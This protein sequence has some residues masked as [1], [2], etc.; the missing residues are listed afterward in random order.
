MTPTKRNS[1]LPIVSAL[2]TLSLLISAQFAAADFRESVSND[3]RSQ[4]ETTLT[5]D[6]KTVSNET[7]NEVVPPKEH[8]ETVI[9]LSNDVSNP[10]RSNMILEGF[11]RAN[12]NTD[13]Q[14]EYI[15][16]RGRDSAT[17]SGAADSSTL[18]SNS[19]GW[20]ERLAE[21]K[22]VDAV[23]VSWLEELDYALEKFPDAWIVN[24]TPR[25]VQEK[26]NVINLGGVFSEYADETVKLIPK[27]PNRSQRAWVITGDFAKNDKVL[28]TLTSALTTAGM[29]D[30]KLITS[31]SLTTLATTLREI[32]REDSIIYLPISY[33]EDGTPMEAIEVIKELGAAS[34]APILSMWSAFIG[35]GAIGGYVFDPTLAGQR[36]W[37]V[38]KDINQ[39]G[40]PKPSYTNAQWVID[41]Q[42]LVRFGGAKSAFNEQ[43]VW[44][45]PVRPFSLQ[46]M[47]RVAW[48]FIATATLVVGLL[49]FFL[50]RE[51]KHLG[52]VATANETLRAAEKKTEHALQEMQKAY[53]DLKNLSEKRD[54]IFGIVAHELRTP[55][56]TIAMLTEE[57][58]TED[59]TEKRSTIYKITQ[60]LLNTIDDMRLLVD[61]TYRRPVRREPFQIE[62]LM[63]AVVQNVASVRAKAD[64]NL[65][66]SQHNVD[67]WLVSDAYR[68]RIALSNLV[69]NALLHA[70]AR[71]VCIHAQRRS[72]NK[73]GGDQSGGDQSELLEWTVI[74]DGK[75]ISKELIDKLFTPF[76]RGD[77]PAEGTGLG[78]HITR[79]LI[80][81]LDG[82]IVC[83]PRERGAEFV[84]RVPLV[85]V[86]KSQI[87]NIDQ[88]SFSTETTI[89]SL[90]I[91]LVEDDPMLRRVTQKLLQNMGARVEVASNGAEGLAQLSADVDLLMTDYFMPEM[92]GLA[93]IQ[94][95][96][97]QGFSGPI[98]GAT[99]ASIGK[100]QEEMQ[101]AGADIVVA[102]PLT[103]AT[104]T[105]VI[106]EL[107]RRE[108][109]AS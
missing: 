78:L 40:A 61:P 12:L 4:A 89:K 28:D 105:W 80:E 33:L 58:V 70:N 107:A 108:L 14:F 74:D 77:T 84:L 55:V 19:V 37:E 60:D 8:I 65:K 102:K 32:P 57:S 88:K 13:T 42:A 62:Q 15:L 10:T 85:A 49:G 51:R 41:E 59:I 29:D 54:E 9:I 76:E 31:K 97:K 63:D 64:V 69:R 27:L 92:D 109:L 6:K 83:Q 81:E 93:L 20:A 43:I 52:L 46:E 95:A 96:R 45:N 91:L 72:L 2:V 39:L 25:V 3:V 36:A 100:Q 47:L 50:L 103:P 30:V 87:Q 22:A 26:P 38:L 66:T 17:E 53:A 79:T 16:L 101:A 86:K 99:A 73:S 106:E 48:P 1:S 34:N 24:L 82:E 94:H 68:L 67:G 23:I 44:V 7:Q 90:T 18:R 11:S 104:V 21:I 5:P 35:N 56:A 71:E 98:V 75:G